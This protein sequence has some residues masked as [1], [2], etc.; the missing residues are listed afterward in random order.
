MGAVEKARRNLA[1]LQ[2]LCGGECAETRELA[3]AIQ[4]N[5]QPTVLTA[6]A[7]TPSAVVT[8]N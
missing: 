4:R 6:E 7:V 2:S 8:Q 1:Q 5:P 3:A